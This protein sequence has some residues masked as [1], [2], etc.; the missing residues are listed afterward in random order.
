MQRAQ[1]ETV[2]LDDVLITEELSQRS[3]RS[4]NWQAE[5]QALHTLARQL[6]NQPETMLQ[7]LVDMALD[8]CGAG[9][10]GVSLLET[11]DGEEIFRARVLAG[12]LAQDVGGSTPR[13]FS[14]C[15]VCLNRGTPVLFSHPERYFTYFQAANTPIVEGLVLPLIADNQALGTIWIMTHDQARHFDAEDVRVMTSLADFMAAALSVNQRQTRELLA[16]NAAKTA[17]IVERKQAEER[18]RAL[19]E[20]LPGGAAFVVDR[21]LRYLLAEGE[22][23]AIA[24]F[25]PEDFVGQ[26]IFEVLPPE[27]AANY[28]PLYRKALAGEPFEHEHHAHN[29]W[30]I[31]RGTPLRADNGEI[32]AVL[33]VSYD[34]SD[35]K[36]AEA[37]IRRLSERNR[38]TLESITDAFA[39]LDHEWRYT[40][41]N[42]RGAQVLGSTPEQLLGQTIWEGLPGHE[43]TPFG[44]LYLQVAQTKVPGAIEAYYPPFDAWYNVRVYP[45]ENGI[46]IFNLDVSDRKRADLALRESEAKYRS[47][48]DSIDEGFCIFEMVYNDAGEAIDF[49]YVDTNPAFERQSGRRPLPGQTMRELF[50][51]AEDMWLKD[52]AEVARTGQPK[53][54]IDFHEDLDRWFD[55]F[56]F[57][58]SNGKNQLAALFSD[59]TDQKRAEAAL[60]ESE[61]RLQKAISIETVGVLF[62]TLDGRITD[63]NDTF[64][65]MSGY[66]RDEARNLADWQDLIPPEFW[67]ATSVAAEELATL[68]K[69]APYEKQH[70]R[71]DG[72]RWWGLFSPMRLKG[73][74]RSAECV[75]FVIDI[76]DRKRAEEQ[77]R[78]AAEMDVFRVKLADALRSFTD[79]VEI[80]A[81]AARVLGEYLNANQVHYG[82]TIGDRVVIQ[83]GYGNGLPPMIGRFRFMDFGERLIADY[84]AGR[85][86][87]SCDVLNDP[88]ITEAE[89][90]VITGVGFQAYVAVPL[91]KEK[92]WV[93]TLAVHSITPRNWTTHEVELVQ[94][95]AERTWA[96]VE[97]AYAEVA[98]H[99]SEQKYRTL[100]DSIDEGLA[101]V[102]MIYDDQGEIVDII[103]RQVNRAYERHGGVYNVVGRSIFDVIPGVEDY[104]LDLYKRVAKTGESVREENYQQ[105]VDR[106]F[107]VYF[108]RIDDNGHF[109]AIVFSDISDRKRREA[110]LR[111]NEV[112]QAFL[113]KLSDILQQFVQPNDIKAAAMRL[114]GEHLGVSRAQY[115]ECDSSGEYYSA[116]GVGY[117][118]GLPL[119]DLKYRI[120]DFGTFVNE[121]F[122]AGRPYRI[123]DLT[124]DPRVSAEEREAYHTYQ[125]RAGAGVPL[126]RGGKLVAILA[127][128]D[129]HPHQWTDLEM[130]LIR[131]TAERIWTPLERAR[132]E[133]ALRESEEKYRTLFASIDEGFAIYKLKRD[134]SGNVVDMVYRETNE[135]YERFTGLKNVVGRRASE[136][137]LNLAPSWFERN[138]RVADTGIAERAE[139]YVADLDRWF[140][141]HHSCV[142]GAG[143]NLIAVVFNDITERKRTEEQQ[144]F[145]LK[146]SDALR[147]E[148]DADS[149]ASRAV[150]MLAEHLHLDRVWISEVFEQ[151]DISTVGPEYRR[152]DLPPMSGVFRL[153]DYPETMRQL[154]TQPMVIHDVASD[155]DFSDSEKALLAQLH[156]RAL[157]V[158]SLRKGQ[159]QVIWAL[160]AA[161]TTPRHW[162]ESERVLLEQV[163]ERVWAAI[164]RARAEVALR[165]SELQRVREQSAREQERQRAESLAQLDRAKTLFFSNV[166]H[167]FRTPLTLSLAPLQ[168]AL[169]DSVAPLPPPQRERLE[170]AHRSANR[171]LKLVNTLLDFSRIEAGRM[172]AV[173]E[174]TDLAMFTTELAS[175]FRSAIERAGL[176]L[177]V[178][179][180]ALPES[181]YV[182]RQMWEKIVL[183][184]LSNAFK[185]TLEGEIVVR[186]HCAEGE[187]VKLQI[188]DTG[189]GIPP[190]ELPH[191]FERFY[192]VRG[193]KARTHEGSGIGLSLVQELIKMHGGI[194]D[195]S[196]IVEQ[197]TCFTVTIPFGTAHLQGDRLRLDVG[198]R[199][200]ATRTLASTALSAATYVEEAERWLLEKAEGRR[201]K[202]E[203]QELHPSSFTLHPSKARILLVDD[204]ADMRDYLTRILS[205]SNQVEAVADGVAA[206]A[207]AQAQVP[208]LVLSDV[209]MPGLDGFELLKALRADARTREVP[210]I[211]LSARAGI[212]SVVEGLQMGADDYLIKPFSAQE[213]VTRV[214]AH[215]QMAQLRLEALRQEKTTSRKK[216]ELLATVSHELN[217]PLVAILGWTR[218]LRTSPASQAVLMKSLETIERNATL[219]AKLIQDLLDVSR[220]TAGK[221]ELNLQPVELQ[222]V[223]ETAIATVHQTQQTKEIQLEC[224]LDP[225][226]IA[227]QGDPERL[228]QIVLNLLTNA[229][230]FTPKGG[231]IQVR[232]D[233]VESQAEI[234]V[235]DTGKGISAEFLLHV[236]DSFRQADS[237][238]AKGLGL[239]LAIA[240]HLV[241][242]HNGSIMAESP[243]VGQG[244]TF[245]IKLP[246][247]AVGE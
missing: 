157:L 233:I 76:S 180:P 15:G 86:A 153:S 201:Q 116:D 147:A 78:R 130:D 73:S 166:S 1:T 213:L 215:L 21:D 133:A 145:L 98:L 85:T 243:G 228:Q 174:P 179:C 24:G 31:S 217:T 195:V 208:D 77:L 111:E 176:R 227:V 49:R 202:A 20:N 23:L 198:D 27:L 119:L 178:D 18:S 138:Q 236:F 70:I 135:A 164:E 155:P 66:S 241:E 156:I 149:V 158:V 9:T 193:A 221:L 65:R 229:V 99:E 186:L 206:L 246:L 219:Q 140:S 81:V 223:I 92:G 83:Q 88:T 106:W 131:E 162:N 79:P 25:K 2:T 44:Q 37:E 121:D 211:L 30:Y 3:P 35:R 196:S 209:M 87:V 82:E 10:A 13:D 194:V 39:V 69:T 218:L 59:V 169:S 128:H 89:R 11:T 125:I 94:E 123:D 188:Q 234:V 64:L 175:V 146:F 114:L 105:D 62:F 238:S 225:L 47:L 224:T 58:I 210:I 113:L 170:L 97:R 93:G 90:Q 95:T 171:L 182:D 48:F 161:I 71:K 84:R 232:L 247:I 187:C 181:V 52:Y 29:H 74:G 207:A 197:G 102:E 67:N 185:F 16:A 19:I 165:E 192:Q 22:A 12:T 200:N 205:E 189:T 40:Y 33:A 245:T 163:G 60:R 56:V 26:T 199:N 14:P 43:E 51:E 104:W 159:H 41:I 220:I 63:A 100:F 203:G 46:T 36:Q 45:T 237:S 32:Y 61:E 122:A 222:S 91:T 17:E 212:E 53:R 184:L 55:V 54:F 118:N 112:R 141:V 108:S 75:E 129:V 244:A 240:R 167:E 160:V 5:N 68:G 134:E 42:D 239:G 214:N 107:D 137:V 4:P 80:Q 150:R 120:D 103:F 144:A 127:I 191:L 115:H 148:P 50:P 117:A 124:V 154:A 6:V 177:I 235:S 151:Q 126:L 226:P 231:R 96:A 216:D 183:N 38:H 143:S 34:I 168:D 110:I 190:E 242:L 204:N 101:I 7:S 230:K 139:D 132:A 173:Y 142:G 72:S 136:L 172:E 28:E 109:V 8:L 152:P 57:P